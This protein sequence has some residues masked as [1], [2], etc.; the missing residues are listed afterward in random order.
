MTCGT[1]KEQFFL[2]ELSAFIAH[3]YSNCK[4]ESFKINEDKDEFERKMSCHQ[5]I[6]LLQR[7]NSSLLVDPRFGLEIP[8]DLSVA[9]EGFHRAGSTGSSSVRSSDDEGM[10]ETDDLNEVQDL[11]VKQSDE[12]KMD[13]ISYFPMDLSHQRLPPMEPIA[14]LL[15]IRQIGD[16]LDQN[17]IQEIVMR[18]PNNTCEFCG[19]I[20][21][22][23][24][25]LTVH[26]RSHT[27]EKPY[28]CSCCPYSCA[29]SSKLTR[30]MKT[31]ASRGKDALQCRFCKTSFCMKSTL[32]KHIEIVSF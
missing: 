10:S 19:K 15:K 3:K 1:C 8:E 18:K 7:P 30:H 14:K 5:N 27:G 25:N 23:T 26:R 11:S 16:L 12:A 9:S 2:T 13:Q 6:Q 20:F 17:S 32:D 31:H 4:A 29:Q 24:S 22:N 21:K 28:T